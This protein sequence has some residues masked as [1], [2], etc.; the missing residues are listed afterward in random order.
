[1][2]AFFARCGLVR[3]FKMFMLLLLSICVDDMFLFCLKSFYKRK[4]RRMVCEAMKT[5]D[6]NTLTL[7]VDACRKYDL[8]ETDPDVIGAKNRLEFLCCKHGKNTNH[9]SIDLHCHQYL[10][11]KNHI[12]MTQR[13]CKFDQNFLNIIRFREYHFVIV[14]FFRS[15]RSYV[16]TSNRRSRTCF[17]PDEEG[18][19]RCST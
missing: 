3:Y 18:Q 13:I 9:K 15:A 14:L 19:F 4:A 12:L 10:W 17:V 8:Q 2:Q 5:Y 6:I 11:A 16:S 7:A 1:M